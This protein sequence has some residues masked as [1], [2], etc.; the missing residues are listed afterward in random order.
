[1]A[2]TPDWPYGKHLRKARGDLS[3]ESAARKIGV[4]RQS[5]DAWERRGV[6]PRS[7][8]LKAIVETFGVPPEAI[9]YEP[10]TGWEWVPTE[11]LEETQHKLD[12]L[13]ERCTS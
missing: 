4:G 8:N 5:W 10:P 9:G 2:G 7:K 6:T 11:T 12:L 3:M 1:M 13:L